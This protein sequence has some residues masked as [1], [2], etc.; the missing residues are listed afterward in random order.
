MA[1]YGN[2]LVIPGVDSAEQDRYM[3]LY[4]VHPIEGTGDTLDTADAVAL[5]ST[6]ADYALRYNTFVLAR[7]QRK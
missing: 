3:N 4:G 6:A 7:V 5:V 2:T 1:I